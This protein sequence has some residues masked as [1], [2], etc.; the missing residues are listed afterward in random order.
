MHNYKELMAIVRTT[1]ALKHSA[2]LISWDQETMMSKGSANQRAETLSALE[3][4]IHLRVTDP[5]LEELILSVDKKKLNSI[6]KSNLKHIEK[7]H[8]KLKNIPVKLAKE[9]A[10][11]TSLSQQAWINARKQNDPKDYYDILNKVIHLKKEEAK[12]L[13]K[14]NE[15]LYDALIDTY[16][17]ETKSEN[18]KSIFDKLRKNIISIRELFEL[19]N[20][21]SFKFKKQFNKTAQLE[22]SYELSDIFG[23]N[24]NIGRIDLSEHPFSTGEGKDVRITTR[25]DE[26]DPFNCIYSTIHETGHAVY[27]QSI[28][29]EFI[30]TPNGHGASMGVHESQSRLFENQ[31]GRSYEF[32]FWLFEKF[33]SK[34]NNFEISSPQEFYE[35]VNSVH[36]NFIR[37]EAD[38]LQY[39]L[40]ILMRFDLELE[41]ING[42]L[43]AIEIESLWNEKFYKDFGFKVDSPNNGFLQ[44]IHWS[45]GLFGYFPTYC[46]GNIYAACIFEKIRKEI[47]DMMNDLKKGNTVKI[48]QW[49]TKNIYNLG[50]TIEPNII[51]KNS[52]N[53]IPDE[54]PLSTYLKDKFNFL[55]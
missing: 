51:I 26:N 54:K 12:C 33:K 1:E 10:H 9:I 6:Q 3:E 32:C 13:K 38:E 24:K 20:E 5:K 35:I 8:K 25:I 48:R 37:T 36:N 28:P 46:L 7:S 41:I 43:S 17:P 19:K 23:F 49:L 40:H 52:I 27:E 30:F 42:N 14:N 22:F 18:L 44:D 47:P 2:G 4:V 39:N 15:S 45:A 55:K 16:E 53:N 11:T 34:F 31:L 21:N 50:N 29:E